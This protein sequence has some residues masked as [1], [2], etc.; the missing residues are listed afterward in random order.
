MAH[1]LLIDDDEVL[2]EVLAEALTAA[3]HTVNQAADGR[4]ARA[5][6]GIDLVITDLV[7]PEGEGLE[8]IAA[9]HRQRP[10]LPIIAI[11]GVPTY[12]AVY[13]RMATRLGAHR[14]L[15]KPFPAAELLQLIDELLARPLQPRVASP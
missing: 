14:S 3:G 4:Q 6:S 9:L 2:R 15:S 12:S 10:D 7:M 11:S 13:L 1:L 8:T 5:C